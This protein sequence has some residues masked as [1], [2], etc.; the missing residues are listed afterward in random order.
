MS[1]TYRRH[2]DDDTLRDGERRRVRMTAMDDAF[3]EPSPPP[4]RNWPMTPAPKFVMRW[5]TA[6]PRCA[7]LAIAA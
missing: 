7:V 1:R 6:V 3:S 4:S 5:A 2:D